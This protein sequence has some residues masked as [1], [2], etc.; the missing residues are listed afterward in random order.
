[1]LWSRTETI[2]ALQPVQGCSAQSPGG[3]RPD[4]PLGPA[5]RSAIKELFGHPF[6]VR[7]LLGKMGGYQQVETPSSN[8]PENEAVLKAGSIM[9]SLHAQWEH[10]EDSPT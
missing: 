6:M 3:C 8:R 4:N 7:E 2:W 1:M 5:A 10:F 9:R